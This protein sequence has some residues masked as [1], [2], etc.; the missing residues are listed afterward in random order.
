MSEAPFSGAGVVAELRELREE[1]RA[2]VRKTDRLF[3][4]VGALESEVGSGGYTVVTS[5]ASA[6]AGFAVADEAQS[7][8]PP[9]VIS[10]E[11][12]PSAAG[13]Q[14]QVQ[15]SVSHGEQSWA[16]RERIAAEIG[17]FLK[18]AVAGDHRGSSGRDQIKLASRYY[19]VCKTFTGEV[20]T[21]P[22]LLFTKFSEVKALCYRGNWGD[23][24]FVGLP[25]QREISACLRAAGFTG[26]LH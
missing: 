18:R 25:S 10:G 5:A 17:L 19:I 8:V 7:V 15:A 4:R 22:V 21:H 1:V 6:S 14:R 24:V 2:L 13:L 23:S 16:E 20:H 26:P 12:V 9:S 11:S 3:D